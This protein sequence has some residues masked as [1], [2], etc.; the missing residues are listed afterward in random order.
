MLATNTH[1]SPFRDMK[2]DVTEVRRRLTQKLGRTEIPDPIWKDL[3]RQNYV[4][5][6]LN[7]PEE[8]A[9]HFR[10]LVRRARELMVMFRQ[11]K[12]YDPPW[13]AI[14]STIDS[15]FTEYVQLVTQALNEP[16]TSPYGM[17]VPDAVQGTFRS[18][19]IRVEAEPWV[20]AA[21][22]ERFYREL[23]GLLLEGRRNESVQVKTLQR[24]LWVRERRRKVRESWAQTQR[25]WERVH[26]SEDH[27]VRRFQRDFNRTKAFIARKRAMRE[28][29]LRLES[30]LA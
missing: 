2:R 29:A 20:P 25:A 6:L 18:G 5:Q 8:E 7:E 19:R 11:A 13:P 17:A 9:R 4:S 22:I 15:A 3:V 14:T 28:E 1:T 16:E 10:T 23:Q 30:E 21:S 24:F 26:G 27:D 12:E